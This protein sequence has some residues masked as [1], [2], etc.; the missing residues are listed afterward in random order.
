MLETSQTT[1]T[2]QPIE[3][4]D[5][6]R[7]DQ[8]ECGRRAPSARVFGTSSPMTIEAS[9]MSRVISTK[10]I[11]CAALRTKSTGIAAIESPTMPESATAPNAEAR[12]PRKVM[13]TWMVARNR[14]GSA[15]EPR[16]RAGTAV[17]LVLE[18]LRADAGGR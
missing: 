17:A 9:A 10:A 4:A 8:R 18:R 3:E 15:V 16:A 12:K 11:S 2:Q 14:L 7:H 5:G 1:G 13:A 6:P